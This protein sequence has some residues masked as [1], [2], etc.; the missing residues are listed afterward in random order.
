VNGGRAARMVLFSVTSDWNSWNVWNFRTCISLKRFE[1]SEAVERL[2]RLER[3]IDPGGR[4][5]S[6]QTRSYQSTIET[7]DDDLHQ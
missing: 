3:S 7:L 1:R 4:V 5:G 6:D 2:E